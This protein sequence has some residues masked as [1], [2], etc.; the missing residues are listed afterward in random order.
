M[1]SV[2]MITIKAPSTNDPIMHRAADALRA[3]FQQMA[4][5]DRA[6]AASGPLQIS[7]AQESKEL[8]SILART[9]DGQLGAE[10]YAIA[11]EPRGEGQQ[12]WI[13]G[14]NAAACLAGAY[15]LLS[16]FG[17][18]F[19]FYGDVIPALSGAL[20]QINVNERYR[21][22]FALRGTQLWCYWYSGRD[23]WGFEAYRSYLDQF[24]KLGLNLFDF[25]L[26]FYEPLYTGYEMGDVQP[27][28]YFLSGR[29]LDHVRVGKAQFVDAPDA[30]TSAAIPRY[31][32]DAERSDAAITLMRQVFNY[33]KSLGIKT[34]V[35]IEVANQLDFARDVA[36]S[37]PMEDR[38]EDGRLIQPSSPS[39]R[40]VLTARLK[41]LFDTYPMCDYY[42]LWQSEAGVFRTTGGS[43]HPDDVALRDRLRAQYFS[44]E[45]SDADYISWLRLAD[46]IVGELKPNARLVTS[47]WGSEAVFACADE[48]L[49]DRFICSSIAPYEPRLALQSGGLDFYRSTAKEKWNVTW[50]ET[51][52]HMWVMQPKLD[53]T[54]EVVDR[55]EADGVSGV[56]VLHWNTLFCDI[57]LG[58]YASQCWSP[59]PAPEEFRRQWAAS[60]YGPDCAQ[61]VVA[62]FAALE[63]LNNLTIES[64]PTMQ[65]WVGYEC[66]INP[67]LQAYRFI[68]VKRSFPDSW[69]ET[70][71]TPHLAYG[72]RFLDALDEAIANAAEAVDR[73]APDYKAQAVRL[74]HRVL[75]VRG[76]YACHMQLAEAVQLWNTAD[77]HSMD[78]ALHIVSS[79]NADDIVQHFIDGLD[80]DNGSTN[81]GELGLLL[82]L[83]EKFLGGIERLKGR[84]ERAISGAPIPFHSVADG[85]LLAI[86][87]GMNIETISLLARDDPHAPSAAPAAGLQREPA[88]D[89]IEGSANWPVTV[90]DGVTS[91]RFSSEL[92]FWRH[93]DAIRVTIEAS[94]H[95]RPVRAHIY[96]CEDTDWDSLFRRQTVAINGETVAECDDFLGQGD[97]MSEGYWIDA[98]CH[99]IDGK[100]TIEI[101]RGGN[102]DVIVSGIVVTAD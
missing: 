79:C 71:V 12:I 39:A 6:V 35:G 94:D 101:I 25:P 15:K 91:Q 61:S 37:F 62:T 70:Y 82:S 18:S 68:D 88:M 95:P 28:G 5:G 21:P 83:N 73:A 60:L 22:R 81:F 86:W 58:F 40:K 98:P 102:S 17:C 11:C 85:A 10:E 69:I 42:G 59:S 72:A 76:L 30:F 14:A 49:G 93:L 45:P 8:A 89:R 27:S 20:P 90:S 32:S 31:G 53:A 1:S 36:N 44:L 77:K 56:M 50:A 96:L 41:A 75:Y 55:L 29:T 66:F 74:H 78:R 26:Y 87:P 34:C 64:D 43:P 47:G 46:E 38:Y 80:T 67:L 54:A 2:P 33:A 9:G 48:L 4:G 3:A 23:V 16:H 84:M 52:Q 51:D 7:L 99:F 24:P 92:G 97:D 13:I 65:S 63:R 19:H 57:N 100:L